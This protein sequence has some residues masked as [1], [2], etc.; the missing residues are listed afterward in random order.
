MNE[1]LIAQQFN[2]HGFQ[3]YAVGGSVRDSLLGLDKSDRDF[4]TDALPNDTFDILKAFGRP[5]KVGIKFGTIGLGDIEIT[6]YRTERYEKGSRKPEVVF[7]NSLEED[8]ARRDFTIN[9]IAQDVLTGEIVD[10]FG[11]QADIQNRAIRA[12][13]DPVDRFTEDPLRMLRAIRFA[14]RLDYEIDLQ[15]L[16]AIRK[17]VR[18]IMTVSPERIQDELNK[19]IV[20][21]DVKRAFT[22]LRGTGLLAYI[23]PEMVMLNDPR[24]QGQYHNKNVWNHTLDVVEHVPNRL[25]VRWAALLHDVGKMATRTEVLGHVHYYGHEDIGAILAKSILKR[26]K[27]D[28]ETIS[29]VT[30]LISYHMQVNYYKDDWSDASVRR[31][32][33]RLG[34]NLQDAIALSKSDQAA[35][36]RRIGMNNGLEARIANLHD[37]PEPIRLPINGN[38]LMARYNRPA[39]P[40]IKEVKAELTE[41]VIEGTLASDDVEGAYRVADRVLGV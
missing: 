3:L 17:G 28:N 38:D 27:Y 15:T 7:G 36:K 10:P 22:I 41:G 24:P 32:V 12:V 26:L 14:C 19:I 18:S 6:T 13:G 35:H 39:G 9:A 8:L 40:W 4:C 20:G 5:H 11:G 2:N 31:L 34:D 33:L 30:Q 21:K 1:E 37:S 29:R 23:A 16:K 25:V